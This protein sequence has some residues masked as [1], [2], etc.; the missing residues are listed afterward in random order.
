MVRRRCFSAFQFQNSNYNKIH[1]NELVAAVTL[2]E[3]DIDCRLQLVWGSV[4]VLW[5]LSMH[6]KAS[7]STL[8]NYSN[9]LYRYN[10]HRKNRYF[11]HLYSVKENGKDVSKVYMLYCCQVGRTKN[12]L[13][14]VMVVWLTHLRFRSCSN[15]IRICPAYSF[16]PYVFIAEWLG[17]YTFYVSLQERLA[18]T[19]CINKI[20]RLILELKLPPT[21]A[22]YKLRHVID[23]INALLT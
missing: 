13:T 20:D 23:E 7:C 9:M 3:G 10:V 2:Y 11:Y 22:Y 16:V 19:V 15:L 17:I 6:L 5:Y 14:Y 8:N 1:I 4:M 18:V 12:L 21:D